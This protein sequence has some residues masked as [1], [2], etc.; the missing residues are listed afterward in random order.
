[1]KK[2]LE[3][4]KA[5]FKWSFE[6]RLATLIWVFMGAFP[7]VLMI[8]IWQSLYR[9]GGALGGFSLSSLVTYYFLV[10]LVNNFTLTFR[11]DEVPRRIK[12]GDLAIDLLR[13]YSFIKQQMADELGYKVLSLFVVFPSYALLFLLVGS[14]ISIDASLQNIVLFLLIVV[15]SFFLTFMFEFALCMVAFFTETA[16]WIFHIRMVTMF[17][18][19][20]ISFPL[21]FYPEKIQ[22]ILQFL[23]YQY[24]VF[25]PTQVLQG[26]YTPA[27]YWRS[28]GAMLF[29]IVIL[30]FVY[31]KLW[32]KGSKSFSAVGR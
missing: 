9:Q 12:D 2:Y 26:S 19:G 31:R 29:W 18:F 3:F 4:F 13:P 28:V 30:W 14:Q 15:L 6:N 23:P 5:S 24:F 8:I 7:V 25:F 16:W 21:T 27:I 32:Q 17:V 20:G 1:M 11:S 22:K 10:G